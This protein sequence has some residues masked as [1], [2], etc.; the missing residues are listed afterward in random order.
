MNRHQSERENKQIHLIQLS[1]LEKDTM[2]RRQEDMKENPNGLKNVLLK[3]MST[4][5]FRMWP[6]LE[7]RSL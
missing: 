4:Q 6:Y 5:N 7:I 2:K 1:T 3:F